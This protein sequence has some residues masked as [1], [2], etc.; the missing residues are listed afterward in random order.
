MKTQWIS[1]NTHILLFIFCLCQYT[2]AITIQVQKEAVTAPVQGSV[3]FSV[4]IKCIGIPT[5]GWMFSGT[6]KQQRIA[7]WTPG[8]SVNITQLYKGRVT[9]YPNGSLTISHLQ[10]QDSGYHIITVTEPSGNS[11]DAGVLLNVTEVLYEDIQ[12]LVVFVIVLGALAAFLMLC[13][14]LLNKLYCYIKAWN[15]RRHLPEHNETELQPL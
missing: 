13:I 9:A 10:L 8:G 1:Q 3:F 12:Y 4:D 5:I 2:Q 14:W 6:S 15:L 7:A 11:K